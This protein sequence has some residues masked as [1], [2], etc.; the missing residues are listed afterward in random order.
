MKILEKIPLAPLP[1][2]IVFFFLLNSF[3]LLAGHLYFLQTAHA[4]EAGWTISSPS[5]VAFAPV[6][7]QV[8]E[9]HIEVTFGSTVDVSNASATTQGFIAQ[10]KTTEPTVSGDATR[11]ISYVRLEVETGVFSSTPDQQVGIATPRQFSPLAFSGSLATSNPI[12]F[13]TADTS[14]RT[15]GT[16][17]IRPKFHLIIP[18]KQKAGS[19]DATLTFE[20]L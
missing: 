18:T 13:L 4:L 14:S 2:R 10:V 1:Q 19:Y 8:L 20:L 16:W 15:A 11:F 17:S 6:S 5:S 9:H 7:W 12:S 3:I